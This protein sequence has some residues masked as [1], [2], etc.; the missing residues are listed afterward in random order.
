MIRSN[1]KL[2]SKI[3][4]LVSL[5]FSIQTFAQEQDANNVISTEEAVRESVKLAPCSNGKRLEAVKKLFAA[6]G[7]KDDEITIEKFGK[8]SNVVVK[9]KGKTDETVIVGAHYDF[10]ELGCGAIDN[11]TGVAIIAHM[12]RTIRQIETQKSFVFVAFDEEEKGLRGSAAMAKAIPVEK[13]AAVCAMLNFDSFGFTAP[14]A[15]KNVSSPKLVAF[16]EKL[17]EESKFRFFNVELPAAADSLTFKMRQIP[18][19]TFSGLNNRWRDFIHSQKDQ[20]GAINM[21]AVY[22]GYRF[23]LVLASRVD[24]SGCQEFR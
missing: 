14:W 7:A 4:L 23:G 10:A 2:T 12:Y 16:A 20:V 3:F 21:T 5:S 9:K 24:A 22:L 15:L 8:I 6:M 17:A 19:I 1:L 13:R 18:A 11:W